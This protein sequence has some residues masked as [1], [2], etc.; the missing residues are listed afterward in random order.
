MHDRSRPISAVAYIGRIPTKPPPRWGWSRGEAPPLPPFGL[1]CKLFLHT[2]TD[3]TVNAGQMLPRDRVSSF[4]LGPVHLLFPA[5]SGHL[6]FTVRLH[7][8]NQ[9]SLERVGNG[10]RVLCSCEPGKQS[11]RTRESSD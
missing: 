4:F 10:A 2:N 9:D 8:S 5:L 7:K 11:R 6:E 3:A 1:V